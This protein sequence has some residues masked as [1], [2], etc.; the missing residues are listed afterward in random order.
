M[1]KLRKFAWASTTAV[2]S[3]VMV[4]PALACTSLGIGK[5]AS[6]D[7]SVM[8]SHTCDG[9]YDHRIQ[10]VEGGKHAAGEMVDIYR[11]PCTDTK[12][13][14]EKVGEIPQVEETFTYFNIGYPFMND[15]QVMMS[16]F[17]WSGRDEVS[18][19]QGLFV[20]ANLEMLGLQ[21]ASTSKEAVQIM[22]ALAEQYGYC[23]GGETLIVADENEA[24]VFEVCGGGL[25]WQPDSGTPGAHWAA[26]RIADDEIFVGANRSR[27]GVIDF[28]DTENF[29]WSTDITELPKQMGWW[30]EG[31]DFNFSHLFNPQPYS[32]PF[33]QSRREWR[34]Q[35]LLAPSQEFPLYDRYQDYA[36][37]FKP[38]EKVT[39]Q[40]IMD[41]YSDHLEGTEYDMTQGLAAGPFHNPTRWGVTSDQ[42]PDYAAKDGHDW[43]REIAQ[44]R[45]SYSFVSQSRS[46]LPDEV[47]GVLWF[48]QDSP[49][50]TV[51][52]PIYCGTTEVPVEWSTGDRKAFDP[53]CA[54][55]AFN[56]V[57]NWANLRWDAMYEE[58][59]EKKASY[60]D[61]F[62]ANQAKVEEEA[63]KLYE[64]NPDEAIAYLTKYVNDNMNEVNE[65]WWDFAWHLVGK[66]YDGMCLDEEGNST[67]LGYPKEW[68]EAVGYAKTSVDDYAKT[69]G[70]EAGESAED[71]SLAEAASSEAAE[72]DAEAP[73]ET[74]AVETAAAAEPAQQSNNMMAIVIA[75]I[76]GAIAGGGIVFATK[77]KQ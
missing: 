8:V 33:Y 29:M 68:L 42:K 52:V 49:D 22:G 56:F 38:D 19:P 15:K 25:L 36:F 9:W 3:L 6:A 17:T 59:R 54:W 50:T 45:C 31:E 21:R 41:V 13:T 66:Y 40:D 51:Y 5:D 24:W 11:D 74:T 27:L 77:K 23:D 7:G 65:G 72:A 32:G 58:I 34:V 10:I 73:A 26:R 48:G 70:E 46:W 16:E 18:N 47:G 69:R 63:A 1:S 64:Q 76:V 39:P 2:M 20:I 35:S 12:T 44:Y 14:P 71:E 57:N 61:V 53:D 55:W 60:E 28:N 4:F 30:T 62:F 37:S 67:T 75:A 43:E